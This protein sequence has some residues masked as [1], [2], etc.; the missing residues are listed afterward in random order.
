MYNPSLCALDICVEV[1]ASTMFFL[2]ANIVHAPTEFSVGH[3]EFVPTVLSSHSV[4][5][6]KL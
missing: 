4:I 6:I 3:H 5:A 2:I 1:S